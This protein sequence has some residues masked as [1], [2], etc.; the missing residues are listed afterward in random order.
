MTLALP[1]LRLA[2]RR[3]FGGTSTARTRAVRALAVVC[4]ACIMEA[5]AI[6]EAQRQTTAN[7]ALSA[8]V[9][10]A[11][12]IVVYLAGGSIVLLS[13]S[14]R[15]ASGSTRRALAALPVSR[16]GAVLLEWLP[17][18]ATGLILL[19]LAVAPAGT[20]LLAARYPLHS[21]ASLI[22][23]S[24]AAG[25]ATAGLIV[26][27]VSV[28]LRE[29]AWAAVRYPLSMLAWAAAV[30][31]AIWRSLA[32]AETG[33]SPAGDIV[34][35][36]PRL[37]RYAGEGVP[38]PAWAVTAAVLGALLVIGLLVPW[39]IGG[40]IVD[41]RRL[42]RFPWKGG[43]KS[44]LA[45]G[46]LVYSTRNTTLLANAV[47]AEV[48][49]IGLCL[50]LSFVP[51]P[52]RIPLLSPTLVVA[53]CLAGS[54]VRQHRSLFPVVRPPQQLID[55]ECMPWTVRQCAIS[56]L[57]FMVLYVPPAFAALSAGIAPGT[58]W[59]SWALAGAAS[60]SVSVIIGW[61]VPFPLDN[62][63]GQLITSLATV[64]ASGALAA[65]AIDLSVSSRLLALVLCSCSVLASAGVAIV[66][67]QRRW[68]E[69]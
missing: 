55:L 17:V 45:V 49:V 6:S 16:T 15:D 64:S 35:L 12:A 24:L 23:T 37:V 25:A 57:W 21:A 47:A 54:V 53:A 69:G 40:R 27:G 50:L 44:P 39:S 9:P 32:A 13:L 18:M 41:R 66:A 51:S 5:L 31:T 48:L 52:F 42:I 38:L 62:A 7:E 29:S 3:L 8:F 36:L 56:L 14:A 22:V 46:E 30:T 58:V 65:F 26:S 43:R 4:A 10:P 61:V 2:Y 28:A 20:A 60:F 67:E 63:P 59:R 1:T 33:G 68:K 34:L 11:V 19:G